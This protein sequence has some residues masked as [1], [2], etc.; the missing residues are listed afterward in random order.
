MDFRQSVLG[1]TQ[2]RLQHW[3]HDSRYFYFSSWHI[4]DG[5]CSDF[6]P[7]LAAWQRLNVQT[8]VVTD[9]P[10][11]EGRDHALSPDDSR[12][13]YASAGAPMQLIWRDITTGDEQALRLPLPDPVLETAQAGN[14]VWSPSGDALIVAA[15]SHNTLCSNVRTQFSLWRVNLNPPEVTA[16]VPPGD[17]LIRP[18]P[19]TLADRIMVRD[20]N[21]LT[22]WMDTVSGRPTTAPEGEPP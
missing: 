22:W 10:L 11:P 13:A 14:I 6:F 17:V 8:G 1:S 20:W 3:S 19:W 21:G 16:L 12:L 18:L 9:Y 4:P 15:A 7:V 5:G 2:T